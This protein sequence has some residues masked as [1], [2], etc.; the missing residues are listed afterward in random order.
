[1]SVRCIVRRAGSSKQ[2]RI[3]QRRELPGTRLTTSRPSTVPRREPYLRSRKPPALVATFPPMWQLPLAPR[4]SGMINP[5]SS[6]YSL[7]L[8]STQPAWH[9]RIPGTQTQM[10]QADGQEGASSRSTSCM[11]RCNHLFLQNLRGFSLNAQVCACSRELPPP[12]ASGNFAIASISHH[13]QVWTGKTQ[14]H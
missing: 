14:S 1:M 5:C 2:Q 13:P 4:S 10:L 11:S 7:S 8:S 6:T 3:N 12:Q 9:T